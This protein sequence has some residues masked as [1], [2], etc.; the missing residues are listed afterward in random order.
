[1]RGY[2]MEQ[3][4][5]TSTQQDLKRVQRPQ[6]QDRP[7][8]DSSHGVAMGHMSHMICVIG[9]LHECMSVAV[10]VE[11]NQAIS[12]CVHSGRVFSTEYRGGH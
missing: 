11:S 8:R 6:Q 2:E 9:H 10:K 12:T 4:S 3:G 1:M 5:K 7:A